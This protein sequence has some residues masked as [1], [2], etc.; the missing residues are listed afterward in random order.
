MVKVLLNDIGSLFYNIE[1]NKG[2][3]GEG[4]KATK[5]AFRK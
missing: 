3:L 4:I 1:G 2:E 5:G